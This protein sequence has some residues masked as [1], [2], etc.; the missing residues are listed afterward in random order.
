MTFAVRIIGS[1]HQDIHP[2]TG[3]GRTDQERIVD[4]VRQRVMA[5]GAPSAVPATAVPDPS[6]GQTDSIRR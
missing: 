5:V 1:V 2:A 3:E 6:A 4:A